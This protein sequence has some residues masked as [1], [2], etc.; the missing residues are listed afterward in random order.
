M[1]REIR[2]S[3]IKLGSQTRLKTLIKIILASQFVD[4][5]SAHVELACNYIVG[6]SI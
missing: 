3:N 4:D 2:N 5:V 1:R 6:R